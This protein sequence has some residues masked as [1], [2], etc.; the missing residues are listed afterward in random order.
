MPLGYLTASAL[1]AVVLAAVIPLLP[2]NI[3]K[4]GVCGLLLA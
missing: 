3:K 2:L 4:G 1:C